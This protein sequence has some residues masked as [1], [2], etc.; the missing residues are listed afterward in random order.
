MARYTG[1]SD[2][3]RAQVLRRDGHRCRWT[4]RSG[5]PLDLHHIEYR[6]GESYDTADNLISLSR[7]AHD[8]VHGAKTPAGHSIIKPVAQLVLHELVAKPGTT[9]L[10]IWRRHRAAWLSAGMCEHGEDPGVCIHC[11]RAEGRLLVE[12]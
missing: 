9:G 8:F 11:A 4:G 3:L 2:E 6:R 7:A 12:H 1:L 10:A 5:V